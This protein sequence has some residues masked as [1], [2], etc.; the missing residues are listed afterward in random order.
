MCC[1]P[2]RLS[3][4]HSRIVSSLAAGMY[5]A[6][7]T[8]RKSVCGRE[9]DT[10]RCPSGAYLVQSTSMRACSADST[11][12]SS[13]PLAPSSMNLSAC[14]RRISGMRTSAGIPMPRATA[15]T[16]ATSRVVKLP[17]SQSMMKKPNPAR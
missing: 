10:P 4:W 12:G 2:A 15:T 11:F 13:R 16:L 9:S 14:S 3:I 1:T 5:S 8:L 17:C 7:V 6:P